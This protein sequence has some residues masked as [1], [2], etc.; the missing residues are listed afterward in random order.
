MDSGTEAF[1]PAIVRVMEDAREPL[2]SFRDLHAVIKLLLSKDGWYELGSVQHV[3][4]C[5]RSPNRC[6]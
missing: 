4:L 5:A 6:I 1:V 2:V 3:D